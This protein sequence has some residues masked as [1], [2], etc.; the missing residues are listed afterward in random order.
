MNRA[1][2]CAWRNELR[3][4]GLSLRYLELQ[5]KRSRKPVTSPEGPRLSLTT[6]GA[7]LT[8]VHLTI[9][10]IARGYL[11]PCEMVLWLD[12]PFS[13]ESLPSALQRLAKRGLRI[14]FTEN[15]GPHTKYF[16]SLELPQALTQ[17]LVIADDDT[18]YEKHWLR[19]LFR[20][21][22]RDS[23]VVH[24]YRAHQIRLT[25]DG[26]APYGTW[27]PCTSSAASFLHFATG[28]S[29]TIL[30]PKLLRSLA[31][32]GRQFKEV[33]PA[34]DDIWLHAHAVRAGLRTAQIHP[35]QHNFPMIPGTQ[36]QT[37]SMEN[38]HRARNDVQIGR[39]YLPSE[40]ATL[41]K[42]A[43]VGK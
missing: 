1:L 16:P 26:L 24:C 23:T 11:L 15:Y 32:S 9:E 39:T 20:A 30:P 2:L 43:P 34:A 8:T 18:L 37:L 19:H 38:V 21:Y 29:G 33:C 7:R 35:R 41:R 17:P 42:E 25:P 31:A 27:V 5:N 22:Q 40:I 13:L 10:S 6:Y 28:V 12:E 36:E 4:L 14:E 3:Y